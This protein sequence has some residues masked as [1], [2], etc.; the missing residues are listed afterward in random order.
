MYHV[1]D[2]SFFE[3]YILFFSLHIS[4]ICFVEQTDSAP[5]CRRWGGW[6]RYH[7]GVLSHAAEVKKKIGSMGVLYCINLSL[8]YCIID[9]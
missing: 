6:W 4:K 7:P 1:Y 2:H 5:P 9:L 8:M 3:L